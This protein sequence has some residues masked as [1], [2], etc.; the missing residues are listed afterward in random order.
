[1]VSRS[2]PSDRAPAKLA[3]PSHYSHRSCSQSATEWTISSRLYPEWLA[4][5]RAPWRD[6]STMFPGHLPESAAASRRS[7]SR[8][9]RNHVSV[10]QDHS[11][12]TGRAGALS[13][14]AK[15]ADSTFV[16]RALRPTSA[17]MRPQPDT[18]F[19]KHGFRQDGAYFCFRA[20]APLCRAHAQSA[21]D[22][23]RHVSNRQNC[24]VEY[25]PYA[26]DAVF[27]V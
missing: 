13:R 4:C 6:A 10:D 7:R 23:V 21:V 20:A 8:Q 9:A 17:S 26:F 11:R 12:L 2:R 22:L 3:A 27:I 5:F 24:T 14:C 16:R 18:T 15:L 19:P 25:A 1:M